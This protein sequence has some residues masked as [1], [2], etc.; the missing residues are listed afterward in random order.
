MKAKLT[1]KFCGNVVLNKIE[2]LL[3]STL[4]ANLLWRTDNVVQIIY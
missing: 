4:F 2:V 1:G 3:S